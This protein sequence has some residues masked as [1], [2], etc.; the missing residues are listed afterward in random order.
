MWLNAATSG[1]RISLTSA[2]YLP[3]I[4]KFLPEELY[5]CWCIQNVVLA[6]CPYVCEFRNSSGKFKTVLWKQLRGGLPC[7]V[8]C[9]GNPLQSYK[10]PLPPA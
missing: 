9:G 3:H 6:P 10:V 7:T 4:D 8:I 1:N 5:D 2:S